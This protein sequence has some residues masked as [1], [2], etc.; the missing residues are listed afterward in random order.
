[1]NFLKNFNYQFETR[2]RYLRG[3]GYLKYIE[4]RKGRFESFLDN[5]VNSKQEEQK[6]S[7]F[8]E[9]LQKF[10]STAK[11]S[12]S[13]V[14]IVMIPDAVQLHDSHMQGVNHFVKQACLKIGVHFIDTTPRFEKE[15][16]PAA[17]YLFPVDP[18]TSPKGH[19]LI[20]AAIADH[21]KKFALLSY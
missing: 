21:I 18:H 14:L 1:M 3:G 7:E 20:A 13:E 11:T 5:T 4:K 16:D 19:G 10:V 6:R 17:L 12:G 8:V 9:T 15:S 2:I